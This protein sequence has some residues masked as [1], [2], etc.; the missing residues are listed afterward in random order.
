MSPAVRQE[1]SGGHDEARKHLWGAGD[2]FPHSTDAWQ[3][4]LR[5]GQCLLVVLVKFWTILS[6]L[7]TFS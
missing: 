1:D 3:G 7:C 5:C 2:N 6:A 4:F